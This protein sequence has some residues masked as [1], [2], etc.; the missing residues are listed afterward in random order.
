MKIIEKFKEHLS[1]EERL[2]AAFHAIQSDIKQMDQKHDALKQS[3]NDWVLHLQNENQLLK[4]KLLDMERRFNRK[5]DD[6]R[7]KVLEL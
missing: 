7:L 5:L 4:Q 3:M 6:R 1:K 2:K